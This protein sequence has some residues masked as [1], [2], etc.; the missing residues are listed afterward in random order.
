MLYTARIS[1]KKENFIKI[2]LHCEYN[3]IIKTVKSIIFSFF[4]HQYVVHDENDINRLK[5]VVLP[6]WN[7]CVARLFHHQAMN[8][9]TNFCFEISNPYNFQYKQMKQQ[10]HCTKDSA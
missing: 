5:C 4:F 8:C 2:K 1:S 3:S 6:I 9:F 10:V 7:S